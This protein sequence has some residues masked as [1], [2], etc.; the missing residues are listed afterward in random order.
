MHLHTYVGVE[1]FVS[2]SVTTDEIIVVWDI[3]PSYCGPVVDYV[4]TAVNLADLSD[5][6]TPTL[7]GMEAT[8]TISNLR[9]GTS[10]SI[11]VAAVNRVGT[12]P[13]SMI[14]VTTLTEKSK[15]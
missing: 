4:V 10:Y 8:Y 13:S 12:G 1:N 14:N 9:N 2:V 5:M 6:R 15:Q 7:N 11:S 3:R